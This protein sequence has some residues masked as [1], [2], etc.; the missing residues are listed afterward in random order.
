MACDLLREA[1]ADAQPRVEVAITPS[2]GTDVERF[3]DLDEFASRVTPEAL[4]EF[5]EVTLL[6]ATRGGLE[7]RVLLLRTTIRA[8]LRGEEDRA[9]LVAEIPASYPPETQQRLM[10]PMVGILRRGYRWWWGKAQEPAFGEEPRSWRRSSI[11]AMDATWGTLAPALIGAL[12]GIGLISTVGVLFPG[13]RIPPVAWI[14]ALALVGASYRVAFAA[15]VPN[16]EI[17][18][19]GRGRLEGALRWTV[20]AL[21]SFAVARVLDAALSS[22]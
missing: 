7:I 9:E 6:A 18:S 5:R 14:G 20:L 10:E 8:K 15:A 3:A 4:T 16:V 19:T 21:A 11:Q 1:D 13:L 2:K 12:V 22:S 17:S